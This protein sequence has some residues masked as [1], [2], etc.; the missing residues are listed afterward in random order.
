MGENHV[1]VAL[2]LNNIGNVCKH[3]EEYDKSQKFFADALAILKQS[4]AGDD[5]PL[6]ATTYGNLGI[7]LK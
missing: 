6:V 7:L 1:E 4:Q 2:T 3:L 5:H